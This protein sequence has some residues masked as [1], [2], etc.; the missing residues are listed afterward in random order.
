MA[1]MSVSVIAT[2]AGSTCIG[3]SETKVYVGD[4]GEYLTIQDAIDAITDSSST[5]PYIVYVLPGSYTPFTFDSKNYITVKGTGRSTIINCQAGTTLADQCHVN[6]SHN[7]ISDIQF[8]F[9]DDNA[10]RAFDNYCIRVSANYDNFVLERCY[11]DILIRDPARTGTVYAFGSNTTF[12]PT[13]GALGFGDLIRDNFVYSDGSGF[14]SVHSRSS[15]FYGNHIILTSRDTG[16][17]VSGID[18]IAVRCDSAGR[19]TWH[20]GRIS[21]GYGSNNVYDDSGNI[22]GFYST[23]AGRLN[24]HDCEGILRNDSATGTG[25]VHYVEV[26][27]TIDPSNEVRIYSGFRGQCER[28]PS[29]TCDL[30]SIKTTRVPW[31]DTNNP[32]KVYV[33]TSNFRT[34]G[35]QG[36][37]AG[38]TY[39]LTNAANNWVPNVEE[40]RCGGE[41]YCDSSAGAFTINFLTLANRSMRPLRIYNL[42][43]SANNVTLGISSGGGSFDVEGTGAAQATVTIAPGT[44]V[45]LRIKSNGSYWVKP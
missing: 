41:W 7:A 8:N 32:G 27:A 20:E 3:N 17:Y 24:I 10:S 44:S 6:G 16:S 40:T 36:E 14:R 34:S 19:V 5:K 22:Y 9:V 39:D 2:V 42:F 26:P 37:I 33:D 23:G 29:N 13:T 28:N 21:S 35:H 18:H 4:G 30:A 43:G 11:F 25:D 38:I 15:D 45:E 31:D 12:S 1:D